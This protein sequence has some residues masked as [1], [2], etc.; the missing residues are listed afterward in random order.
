MLI[1]FCKITN[2]L[3]FTIASNSALEILDN[4]S[5]LSDL[6]ETIV[7]SVALMFAE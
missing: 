6:V 3:V 1:L 7:V 5:R 4:N 2:S